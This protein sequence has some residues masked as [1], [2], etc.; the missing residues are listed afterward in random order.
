MTQIILAAFAGVV[1]TLGLGWFV[2][3]A[4]G[5]KRALQAF[6]EQNSEIMNGLLSLQADKTQIE[7]ERDHLKNFM[8]TFI[9]KPVQAVL[10]DQ[11]FMQLLQA[12]QARIAFE[13]DQNDLPGSRKVN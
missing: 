2:N 13:L 7:M 9:T 6:Q 8:N 10:H 5:W 4:L 12:I 3:T 11:Q 1:L